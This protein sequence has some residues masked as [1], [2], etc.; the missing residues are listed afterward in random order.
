MLFGQDIKSEVVI[1]ASQCSNTCYIAT[2]YCKTT[3]FQELLINSSV[4]AKVKI[5]LLRWDLNDL[6]TGASDLD[7]YSLA[8]KHGWKVFIN[9]KL[10]AKVYRFDNDCYI[11]SANLTNR[12]MIGEATLRNIEVLSKEDINNDIESWFLQLINASRELDDELYEQIVKD[13]EQYDYESIP[14]LDIHYSI[15]TQNLLNKSKIEE[16]FTLDFFWVEKPLDILSGSEEE[17]RNIEH[18]LTLLRLE[19]PISEDG[20]SIAFH[21][22]KAFHWL[23]NILLERKEVYFGELTSLLHDALHDDPAPYRKSVKILL[24]NLISWVELYSRDILEIDKPNVS[25]R[26]KLCN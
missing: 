15:E 8:K 2:A 1:S 17:R 20:M 16:L 11:G 19:P 5:L 13:V 22:S 9:Q 25:T 23:L 14:S 6:I 4:N 7:T 3:A 21:Q 12:G 18:D 10:H 24:N 26:I